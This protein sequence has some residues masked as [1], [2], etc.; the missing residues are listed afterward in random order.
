L[1]PT[2]C[3]WR[4][5]M[6]GRSLAAVVMS[7]LAV[8]LPASAQAPPDVMRLFGGI[9]GAAIWEA[10]RN[11][12]RK[13]P[14]E[15]IACV[16]AALERERGS[17][18][19]LA[20]HGVGPGDPRIAPIHNACTNLRSRHLRQNVECTIGSVTSY[21]DEAFARPDGRGGFQPLSLIEA[22]QYYGLQRLPET[23]LFERKDAQARRNQMQSLNPDLDRVPAPNFNCAKAKSNTERAICGSLSTVSSRWGVWRSLSP[24]VA[25][26]T[27][28]SNA[29]LVKSR[30]AGNPA[31]V[32]CAASRTTSIM[33]WIILQSSCA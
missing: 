20:E 3:V 30:F 27:G 32:L 13:L 12:W 17:I 19:R 28:K 26:S 16:N 22:V 2:R 33:V 9:I 25:A 5:E 8:L 31:M 24:D 14:S 11:E 18:D 21:C 7:L 6:I 1:Q 10:T 29:K 4:Q 15:E 23:A